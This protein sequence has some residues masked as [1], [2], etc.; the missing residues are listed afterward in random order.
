MNLIIYTVFFAFC[1]KYSIAQ[2][3]VRTDEVFVI[4]LSPTLFNVSDIDPLDQYSY[5]AA[6]HELPDLPKWMSLVFNPNVKLGFIYGTPP[7]N[8][9]QVKLDLIASN[10][11]T[12][13]TSTK[14]VTIDIFPKEDPASRQIKMKIHNLNVEDLMDEHRYTKLLDVFRKVLWPESSLDLHL[15]E[16]YSALAA[17]GRR[18]ARRQDG[19]GVVLTLGSNA[20]FSEVLRELER[21]VSP[22]WL[23]RQ[24]PRDFKKTSS[25][26]YFRTKGFLLDWCSFKLIPQNTSLL[27]L[28]SV[29]PPNVDF[30]PDRTELVKINQILSE[31]WDT[32]IWNAPAKWEIPRRSYTEEGV[33]AVFI[34]LVMLLILAALLTAVLGVHPE[35]AEPE[36]GQEGGQKIMMELQQLSTNT[37]ADIEEIRKKTY[38]KNA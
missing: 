35:G 37:A 30:K 24:C 3:H 28:S 5:S 9:E 26:R 6:L 17:G 10:I 14:E 4:Q 32:D 22:L 19:E 2:Y 27:V 23:L 16:L 15:V 34:P 7:A 11:F 31:D 21:E 29:A 18:P 12:F 25:E 1:A 38:T 8:L 20:E 33:V 13:E 36:E